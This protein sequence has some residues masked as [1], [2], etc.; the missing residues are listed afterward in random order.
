MRFGRLAIR[1]A[2]GSQLVPLPAPLETQYWNGTAF[3]TNTADSCTTVAGANVEM[4]NL[5]GGLPPLTGCK[6]SVSDP[7]AFNSGRGNL[8]LSKPT[9]NP[10]A[11]GSVDL[12]VRLEQTVGAGPQSCV[13]GAVQA[14][15]GANRPYLYGQW[16]GVDQGSD[17]LL[18]DD[19]PTAKATF[20]VYKGSEEVI[21]IRENF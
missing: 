18:Y 6:T 17:G 19:N 20:G 1:N 12:R 13:A 3:V 14:V 9:G 5:T 4:S 8:R 2:N 15:T 7:I 11:T 21:F 16:D 10:P